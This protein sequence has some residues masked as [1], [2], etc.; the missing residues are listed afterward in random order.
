MMCAGVRPGS[1]HCGRRRARP[2][3]TCSA[4]EAVQVRRNIMRFDG[5]SS[6]T[7][8]LSREARESGGDGRAGRDA[9]LLYRFLRRTRTGSQMG[10]LLRWSAGGGTLLF[11]LSLLRVHERLQFLMG[12]VHTRRG[13]RRLGRT[14]F[15]VFGVAG[16]WERARRRA[17]RAR[18]EGLRGEKAC[19]S[20]K[21][22]REEAEFPQ[23]EQLGR[24]W[25]R[26][27]LDAF[28]DFA[29]TAARSRA[30]TV[31]ASRYYPLP[32][33]AKFEILQQ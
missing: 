32:S 20:T 11:V 12:S 19:K 22:G 28:L 1:P 18:A 31:R 2:T 23:R 16:G 26:G 4:C 33:N 21:A 14:W 8:R 30:V 29:E 27:E 7:R 10:R 17:G 24:G 13:A 3:P 25:R 5:R 9:F 6:M 15:I